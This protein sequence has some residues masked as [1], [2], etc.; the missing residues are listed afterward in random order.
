MITMLDWNYITMSPTIRDK[1]D[2]VCLA[3]KED[4][5]FDI[6]NLTKLQETS[7]NSTLDEENL[8]S[9]DLITHIHTSNLALELNPNKNKQRYKLITLQ[10]DFTKRYSKPL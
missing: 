3:T 2:C 4:K 8:Q 1:V 6:A 9:L 7:F 10:A 5:V